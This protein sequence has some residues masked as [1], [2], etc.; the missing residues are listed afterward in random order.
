MSTKEKIA[1]GHEFKEHRDIAVAI[2]PD[3]RLMHHMYGR[4]CLEVASLSWLERK[5]ASTLFGD[6]PVASYDDALKAFKTADSLKHDWKA[7]HCFIAKTYVSMKKYRDAI[8]WVDSGLAL[9][10]DSEEEAVLENDLK[11]MR[12]SYASYR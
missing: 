11:D 12:K 3:D 4:W 9:P 1:Y 5:V 10:N 7:N 6:P 2:N 8:K